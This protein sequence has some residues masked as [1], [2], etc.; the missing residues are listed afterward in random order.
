MPNQQKR[1]TFDG[2]G[3]P[4]G[5]LIPIW[6]C[7]TEPEE[8]PDQVY[9]TVCSPRS[10]KGPH[11]HM[12]RKGRFC[13]VRGNVRVVQ[14][15]NGAYYSVTIG[16]DHESRSVMVPAGI[17]TAIYNDSPWDAYVINMPTPA[18]SP[19]D[20]DDHAVENWID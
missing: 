10:R 14:R 15:A 9:L 16:D 19:E 17:P 5:F 3:K 7:L 20:P 2:A 8:R 1:P 4:N 13:C 12:R 6:N 18:W 11:L